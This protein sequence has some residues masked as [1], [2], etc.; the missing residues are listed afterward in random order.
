[1]A[2]FRPHGWDVSGGSRGARRF[3]E[4]AVA[5]NPTYKYEPFTGTYSI[6]KN[7]VP[8]WTDRILW[9]HPAGQDKAIQAEVY[10]AVEQVNCSDHRPIAAH[11]KVMVKEG[12]AGKSASRGATDKGSAACTIL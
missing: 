6:K 12:D 9:R 10:A 2:W 11:F 7:R 3:E 8:S 4:A 1:M 5:F